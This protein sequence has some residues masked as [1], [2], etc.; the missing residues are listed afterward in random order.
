MMAYRR[1]KRVTLDRFEGKRCSFRPISK[2][3]NKIWTVVSKVG[4]NNKEMNVERKLNQQFLCS[5]ENVESYVEKFLLIKN[6]ERKLTNLNYNY[7]VQFEGNK[8]VFWC[9][10][11][12]NLNNDADII[13]S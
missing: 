8:A 2:K 3:N 10:Q 11:R 5:L 12:S 4:D 7:M 1:N 13:P 9:Q 6:I